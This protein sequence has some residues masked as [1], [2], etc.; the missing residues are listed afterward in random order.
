MGLKIRIIKWKHDLTM[1]KR[2]LF[3]LL[4]TLLSYL[5]THPTFFNKTKFLRLWKNPMSA[6]EEKPLNIISEPFQG[7]HLSISFGMA[8]EYI[9]LNQ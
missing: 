6:A 1:F 2:G 9:E 4:D 8:I 5:Y 7:Q 3:Y